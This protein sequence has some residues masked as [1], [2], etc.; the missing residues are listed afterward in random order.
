MKKAWLPCGKISYEEDNYWI[1]ASFAEP[2]VAAA[3]VVYLAS[4]G[5]SP[6]KKVSSKHFIRV[7]LIANGGALHS[8]GVDKVEAHCTKSPLMIPV[9]HDMT[10]PYHKTKAVRISYSVYSVAISSVALHSSNTL[11]P[12][13]ASSC[14]VKKNEYYNPKTHSCHSYKCHVPKCK[15]LVINNANIKCKGK[16][17]RKLVT[18]VTTD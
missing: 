10:R 18:F 13:I 5:L 7:K 4:D 8:I 17:K 15:P 11:N 14:D 2:V 16:A 3:V 1:E 9:L 6:F 12:A